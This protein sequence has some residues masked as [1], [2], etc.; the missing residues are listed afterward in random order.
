MHFGMALAPAHFCH[1]RLSERQGGTACQHGGGIWIPMRSRGWS[2]LTRWFRCWRDSSCTPPAAREASRVRRAF[3]GADA[4][5]VDIPRRGHEIPDRAHSACN[6]GDFGAI[7]VQSPDVASAITAHSSCNP[8]AFD[9]L[10][11]C[12]CRRGKLG[13]TCRNVSKLR[14][15]R[16]PTRE[17]CGS[18]T[19]STSGQHL[20]P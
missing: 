19:N 8:P 2:I 9:G 1:R 18:E 15:G 5:A 17:I 13:A 7:R 10:E 6:R 11:N 14:W 3:L 20:F 4:P 12:L 16:W